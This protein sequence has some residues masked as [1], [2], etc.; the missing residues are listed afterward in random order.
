MRLIESSASTIGNEA[1]SFRPH[2]ALVD[3]ERMPLRRRARTARDLG[4]AR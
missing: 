4:A 2:S 3:D 1:D